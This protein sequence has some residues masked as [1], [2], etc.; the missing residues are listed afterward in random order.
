MVLRIL[1]IFFQSSSGM[2]TFILLFHHWNE[3]SIDKLWYIKANE[4]TIVLNYVLIVPLVCSSFQPSTNQ[5]MALLRVFVNRATSSLEPILPNLASGIILNQLILN[6]EYKFEYLHFECRF[7]R[8]PKVRLCEGSQNRVDTVRVWFRRR[9]G[10]P[11]QWNWNFSVKN[12]Q[13]RLV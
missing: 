1:A 2:N 10:E 13:L 6:D 12:E 9:A 11:F 8:N 7:G 5:I 4:H 3:I